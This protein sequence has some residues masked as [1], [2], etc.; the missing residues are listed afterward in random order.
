MAWCASGGR[1]R[2]RRRRELRDG[3]ASVSVGRIGHAVA[4]LRSPLFASAQTPSTPTRQRTCGTM[5]T[6][7]RKTRLTIQVQMPTHLLC[8]VPLE[9]QG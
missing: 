7:D 4:R 1:R 8:T 9:R 2:R 6:K 3:N 5:V